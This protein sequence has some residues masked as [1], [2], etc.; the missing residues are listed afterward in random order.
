MSAQVQKKPF[1]KNGLYN[2]QTLQNYRCIWCHEMIFNVFY[3]LIKCLNAIYL[4]VWWEVVSFFSL[5]I[6]LQN[7]EANYLYTH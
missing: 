5:K 4:S 6:I 1:L 7:V 3:Y 2:Y